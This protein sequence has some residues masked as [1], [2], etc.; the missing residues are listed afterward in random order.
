MV[1]ELTGLV[2]QPQNLVSYHVG[3]LRTAELVTARRS[4]ADGR[5]TFYAADLPRVGELLAATGGA[6]HPGLRLVDAPPVPPATGR[7]LFLCTGNSGRSPMA[8][9][10]AEKLSGGSVEAHSAGSHPKPLHPHALHVMR[11]A[12]GIDLSGHRP[13]HVDELAGQPFDR[14]ITLCD[15]VREVCVELPGV[16]PTAHWS[17]ADPNADDPVG[18]TPF[19]ATAAE[20]VTRIGFLLAT[21]PPDPERPRRDR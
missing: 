13:T 16:E 20:L 18:D 1:S 15:R 8:A 14:V 6:L 11:E 21:L 3:K 5:D 12:H 17:M 4:S 2:G 19:R 9:S 7:V 10:L